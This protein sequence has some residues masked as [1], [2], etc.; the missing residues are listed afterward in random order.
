LGGG[1][2]VTKVLE[3]AEAEELELFSGQEKRREAYHELA[4]RVCELSE[5]DLEELRSG[6]R[7]RGVARARQIVAYIATRKLGVPSQDVAKM[8]NVSAPAITAAAKKGIDEMTARGWK[9]D[10]LL[11]RCSK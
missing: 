6:S 7:R 8:M 11:K 2:F 5:I 3:Q 10:E 4:R 9:M 1:A